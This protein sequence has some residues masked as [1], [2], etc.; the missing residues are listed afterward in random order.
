MACDPRRL[1]LISYAYPPV[2]GGGVQRSVKFAKYL[3]QYQWRPTVLTAADPSVPVRD[4]DLSMELDPETTVLRAR[5]FEPSYRTKQKLIATQPSSSFSPKQWIRQS[6]RKAAMALLQPD[7]QVLWNPSA[8]RLATR[9]L[10]GIPHDAVYVTGPPFSSFLLGRTLKRRF[11]LPLV[12]DFRDEWLLAI[13]HFE[14]HQR[15][16]IAIRRQRKMLDKVLRAADAVVATTQSSANELARQIDASGGQASVHCIYNGYDQDDLTGLPS[17]PPI[18]ERLRIVY[19]GTLWKLTDISPIV[20]ALLR[21]STTDPDSA[22]RIDLIIA[23]RRTP[24]QD[25]IVGKLDPTR[26]NVQ[27][28][29]YLPHGK[30]LELAASADVLLLLLADEPGA[31]RVVPAKLFEYLALKRPILAVC[32]DGETAS[33]VGQHRHTFRFSPT[34]TDG[35]AG[36]LI[37]LFDQRPSVVDGTCLDQFSRRRQAGQLAGI[38]DSVC[39]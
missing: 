36:C 8:S 5:T 1:L 20:D 14:N 39:R 17:A 12:L 28:H 6:A 10:R 26:V 25:A 32:G 18:S 22:A 30:S 37:K 21:L 2:G 4:S 29:D 19:T 34:Q 15:S 7:P 24:H 33:L 35:I 23:G 38:M 3:P 13:R 16:V 9:T 31:E 27:R 11:G